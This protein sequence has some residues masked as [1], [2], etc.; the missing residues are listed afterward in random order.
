MASILSLEPI[1]VPHCDR[2]G[3]DENPEHSNPNGGLADLNDRIGVERAIGVVDNT[4]G[5]ELVEDD[6]EENEEHQTLSDGLS[7]EKVPL[8]LGIVRKVPNLIEHCD[9]QAFG[10]GLNRVS[11][12]LKFSQSSFTNQRVS[13]G[14]GGFA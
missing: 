10:R 5:Q 7:S 13:D 3:Q 4:D 9:M 6:D 11:E 14:N 2:C 12:L 1:H 8:R